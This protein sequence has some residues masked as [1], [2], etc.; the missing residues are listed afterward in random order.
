MLRICAVSC[1][2]WRRATD[3]PVGLPTFALGHG[4]IA[5]T[6]STHLDGT[7][8]YCKFS[9]ETDRQNA[10]S[11]GPRIVAYDVLSAHWQ[12]KRLSEHG[13]RY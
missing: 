12:V 7:P 13:R 3:R 8:Y 2:D 10:T 4:T 11:G 1:A 6:I 5:P 9:W